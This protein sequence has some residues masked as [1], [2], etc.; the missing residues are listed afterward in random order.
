MLSLVGLIALVV[1]GLRHA[2]RRG[3]ARSLVVPTVAGLAFAVEYVAFTDAQAPRFLLPALAQLAVPA[4]F[5]VVA[6]LDRVREGSMRAGRDRGRGHPHRRVL[7]AQLAIA[8]VVED[9][10]TRQ[11]RPAD[12]AGQEVRTL[13]A[14]ID[15]VLSDGSFPIVGCTS[16]CSAAPIASDASSWSE[17][18][19]RLE[20]E[21]VTPFLVLLQAEGTPPPGGASELATIRAD[22]ER[23]WVVYGPG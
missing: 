2:S 20:R 18:A 22:D 5:G 11:R 13:A 9:A 1:V 21:G 19:E 12:R 10:V 7:A 6:L 17:R 15:V 14:G 16:G 3:L 8:S 4:G 23:S